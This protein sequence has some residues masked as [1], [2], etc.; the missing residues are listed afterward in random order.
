MKKINGLNKKQ[1]ITVIILVTVFVVSLLVIS[2]NIS[3]I[4]KINA[5]ISGLVVKNNIV[6]L[7]VNS[8]K[9]KL[10]NVTNDPNISVK[11]NNV[12]ISNSTKIKT[13]DILNY[14]NQNYSIAILGDTNK[15]GKV[16]GTD[17]SMIYSRYRQKITFDEVQ[18]LAADTNNDNNI[19]GSDVSYTYTLY[20]N[21][22][23]EPDDPVVYTVTLDSNNATTNGSTSATVKLGDT[24][25]SSITLPQKVVTI[26]YVN[27]IG[28]SVSGGHTQRSYT[29]SGWYTSGGIKLANNTTIPT[30]QTNIS[31]YTNSNG[32]WIKSG[33]TTLYAHWNEVTAI[34]PVVTK[35]GGYTCNW[36]TD[37]DGIKYVESGGTWTFS[38]ANSRTFTANCTKTKFT[39]TFSSEGE[40]T[41]VDS[42]TKNYNEEI[43]TLP[44][45]QRTGYTFD[46]WYTSKT[47]GNKITENTKVTSDI[48]YYAH[49]TPRQYTIT[50]NAN[51]GNDVAAQTKSYGSTLNPLPTATRT[52]YTFAGWFTN[53]SS[54]GTQVTNSTI[55]TGN[56]RYYAHWTSKGNVFEGDRYCG[57]NGFTGWQQINGSYY[58]LVNDIRQKSRYQKWTDGYYYWL[59]ETSGISSSVAWEKVYDTDPSWC[60]IKKVSDG[61]Y[62]TNVTYKYCSDTSC[63]DVTFNSN[64]WSDTCSGW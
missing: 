41:S 9:Q 26:S 47:G 19:T 16:T 43:G 48:T 29:L 36:S 44:S 50:Y 62:Y 14:N 6:I 58:Y 55:V 8:T 51:G 59:N 18:T 64:G 34:L 52:C 54:T 23:I 4:N 60:W 35:T 2:K 24:A 3:Q 10:I 40:W 56:A 61:T 13:G 28:A 53:P 12:E 46:G 17:V 22:P 1:R 39:V 32:Q 15:D 21:P 20:R 42:I 38:S 49:W 5:D 45:T 63:R 37:S 57:T 11:S 31:G 25:L 33:N 7:N 30:L 27:T